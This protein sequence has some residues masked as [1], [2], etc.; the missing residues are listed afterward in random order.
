MKQIATNGRV[1]AART[2]DTLVAGAL[3][4]SLLMVEGAVLSLLGPGNAVNPLAMVL[5]ASAVCGLIA[6]VS[7]RQFESVVNQ[8]LVLSGISLAS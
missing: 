4:A 2:G 1:A 5:L 6:L 3:I 7:D 8:R